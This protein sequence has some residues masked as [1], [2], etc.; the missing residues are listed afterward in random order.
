MRKEGTKLFGKW[1][2]QYFVLEDVTFNYYNQ[3]SLY[4][5]APL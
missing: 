1:V 3:V 4:D 5:K 2:A